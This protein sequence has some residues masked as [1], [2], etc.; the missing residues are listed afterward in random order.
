MTDATSSD[1]PTVT[2]RSDLSILYKVLR[3]T[4]RPFRSHVINIKGGYPAGSPRLEKRP[5][6][7]GKVEVEER[8]VEIFPSSKLSSE[9]SSNAQSKENVD[10]LWLYDFHPPAGPSR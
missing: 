4:L 9:P 1:G 5:R 3:K 7:V 10:T 8:R 2:H 6:R